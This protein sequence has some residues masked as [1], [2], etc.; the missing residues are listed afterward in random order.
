MSSRYIGKGSRIVEQ[1]STLS[2]DIPATEEL[3]E[4]SP[5]PPSHQI[6]PLGLSD[7]GEY[8]FGNDN[9][10]KERRQHQSRDDSMVEVVSLDMRIRLD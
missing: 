3:E 6:S 9:D 7:S 1:R 2:L 5:T 4:Q 10:T 8:N